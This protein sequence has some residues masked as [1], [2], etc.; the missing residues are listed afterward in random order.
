M[1]RL[2]AGGRLTLAKEATGIYA[3]FVFIVSG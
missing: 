3:L 1:M 2:S